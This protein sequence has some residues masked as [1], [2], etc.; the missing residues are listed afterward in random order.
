MSSQLDMVRAER[1]A[2]ADYLATLQ[3]AQWQA[4]TLCAGWTVKDVVTHVISYEELGLAGL[5]RRFIRGRVVNANQVGVDD[6]RMLT[7]DQLVDFLRAHLD[8]RGLT[9]AFGGMI[10][11]VDGTIHQQ[12]IRRTLGHPREIPADRLRRVLQLTRGNPRLGVPRRIRGLH[13]RAVDIDWQTGRGAQITGPAEA[14]MMA[15]AGRPDALGELTGP[16]RAV[17]AARMRQ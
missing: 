10:A 1:G 14:L 4:T 16:G 2:F 5:A 17:L 3:P 9:A 11:L 8:P 7:P 12:D 15:M 6:Y 13:L